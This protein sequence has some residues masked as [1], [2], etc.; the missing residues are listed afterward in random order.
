MNNDKKK[1]SDVIENLFF[2]EKGNYLFDKIGVKLMFTEYSFNTQKNF[3]I[4]FLFSLLH[5]Y[6][7]IIH[8]LQHL[9]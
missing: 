8:L 1:N 9:T 3:Q 7:N 6:F 2:F 4:E 5:R